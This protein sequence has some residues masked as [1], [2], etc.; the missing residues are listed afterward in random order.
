[1]A[2]TPEDRRKMFGV[3]FLML[4][5][6]FF[7][8]LILVRDSGRPLRTELTRP[9][10][11]LAAQA[12]PESPAANVP[13]LVGRSAVIRGDGRSAYGLH[14]AVTSLET[15]DELNDPRVRTDRAY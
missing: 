12:Q 10:R 8:L 15:W 9:S 6:L 5:G 7:L 3:G 13:S 14:V 11:E 4:V 1:M 2:L